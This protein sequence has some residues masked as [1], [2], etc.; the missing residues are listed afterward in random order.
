[1]IF[2]KKIKYASSSNYFDIVSAFCFSLEGFVVEITI[3]ITEK[4]AHVKVRL[5]STEFSRHNEHNDNE[6]KLGF[7]LY[8]IHYCPLLLL[9][10][11]EM[12]TT[13]NIG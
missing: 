4:F 8:C 7:V 10:S 12:Y 3:K 1:L 13:T 6:L 2:I 11:G 5:D 9:L